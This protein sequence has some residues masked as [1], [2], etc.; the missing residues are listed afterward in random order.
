MTNLRRPTRSPWRA[1]ATLVVVALLLGVAIAAV[2]WWVLVMLGNEIW[3][4]VP[5][6]PS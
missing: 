5:Q 1:F 6:F 4:W 3:S 2:A